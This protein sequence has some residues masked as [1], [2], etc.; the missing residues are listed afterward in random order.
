[1]EQGAQISAG[2]KTEGWVTVREKYIV[3]SDVC[4]HSGVV[5]GAD[6]LDSLERRC[7]EKIEQR[8]RAVG[9]D[10]E[11]GAN[12]CA[13]RGA[14][15]TVIGDEVKLDN[16][17]QLVTTYGLETTAMAGC[18]GVAGSATIGATARLGRRNCAGAICHWRTASI[19]QRPHHGN[20]LYRE[21]RCRNVSA[22]RQRDL[23]KRMPQCLKQLNRLRE[24]FAAHWASSQ[25]IKNRIHH[26]G[27]S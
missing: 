10:V 5:I 19:F 18:V 16:L 4:F 2:G 6:S 22:G 9:N 23:G 1:V 17:I 14:L 7:Q 24:E 12:T 8:W 11:I 21:G 13:D 15:I 20:P 25:P 26:D 27:Y 3:V